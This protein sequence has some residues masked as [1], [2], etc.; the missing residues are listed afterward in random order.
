MCTVRRG[1]KTRLTAVEPTREITVNRWNA[2]VTPMG[3]RQSNPLHIGGNLGV[4]AIR[5]MKRKSIN[6][7]V[8][9]STRAAGTAMNISGENSRGKSKEERK[10]HNSGENGRLR[11]EGQGGGSILGNLS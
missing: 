10:R 4:L 6:Q 8:R 9:E 1:R 2:C 5:R 11:E 7:E 3:K